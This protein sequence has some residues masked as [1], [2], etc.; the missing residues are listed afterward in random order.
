MLRD[1]ILSR[2]AG[3]LTYGMTPPKAILSRAQ[4]QDIS[5]KQVERLVDLDLDGLILY[6]IQDEADRTAQERPFPY[7]RTIDPAVYANEYLSQVEVSKIIYRCVGKYTSDE[8]A[9]WL[10]S[11][12]TKHEHS[13]FVGASSSKQAVKLTLSEAYD[14]ANA[15]QS[16]VCVGGVMIPE[17]HIKMNNEHLRMI[18]KMKRGC[19]FFVSQATYNIEATRNLLSDY[20]YYCTEH[21]IQMVPIL[22]N[23]SPCGSRKTLDF[24]KWLGISI[25]KWLENEL[26]HSS[27]SLDRSVRLIMKLFDEIFDFALEKGIPVGCSVESVSTKRIEIEASIQLVRD[28]K[29]LME[30]KLVPSL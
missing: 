30:R 8:F 18:S 10:E 17:R 23:L 27:D 9:T 16:N 2:R 13:V 14:L 19:K 25:P 29:S 20:F 28:L 12:T 4:I 3:I 21:G 6:D 24:M 1:K 22:I 5:R 11:G 26:W 7:I 15:C